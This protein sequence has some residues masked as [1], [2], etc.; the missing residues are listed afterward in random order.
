MAV[1]VLKICQPQILNKQQHFNH[2]K[3]I[4]DWSGINIDASKTGWLF[5]GKI[6]D[7]NCK[8]I[9]TTNFFLMNQGKV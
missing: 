7:G 8:T 2:L 6:I 9:R 3:K 5:V 4:T 1:C